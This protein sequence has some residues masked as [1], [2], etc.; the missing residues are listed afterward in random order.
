M[1]DL[2]VIPHGH[3]TIATAH[4]T[5]TQSPIHTPYQ[6]YLVKWNDIHQYF[7]SEPLVPENGLIRVPEVPGMGMALNP[8]H[9]RHQEYLFT[10]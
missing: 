2:Q 5:S 6:E 1:Y 10:S 8:E 9:I 4:F 3:S 7:L